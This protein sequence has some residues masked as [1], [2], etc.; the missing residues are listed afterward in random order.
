MYYKFGM[1][2]ML[3]RFA[4]MVGLAAAVLL[5]LQLPLAGRLKWLDRIFSI[6]GLYR[7][8]RFNAYLIG[9]LIVGHPLLVLAPEG[10]WMVPLELRYWPEWVGVS[11]LSCSRC[12]QAARRG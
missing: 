4:K 8:H 11:L 7:I 9:V 12:G 1:D 6:P 10:R 2:K 3:L 5:L